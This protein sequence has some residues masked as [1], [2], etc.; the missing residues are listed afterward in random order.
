MLAY[1]ILKPTSKGIVPSRRDHHD[2]ATRN[3]QKMMERKT[4]SAQG[5]DPRVVAES[6]RFAPSEF[7]S[8]KTRL[9][10]KTVW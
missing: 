5:T 10:R 3:P 6:T 4:R 9:K 1:G 2:E 8:E 7:F